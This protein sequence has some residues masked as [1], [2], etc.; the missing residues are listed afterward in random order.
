[1]YLTLKA[2]AMHIRETLEAF[3]LKKR[4]SFRGS[5]AREDSKRVN[6]K[7]DENYL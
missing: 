6:G 4:P 2:Y 5:Q 1:M 3:L 7:E